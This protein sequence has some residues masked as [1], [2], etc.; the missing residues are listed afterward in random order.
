MPSAVVGTKLSSRSDNRS[1]VSTFYDT[2]WRS[3]L[4]VG[5]VRISVIFYAL[6]FSHCSS[7]LEM[8]IHPFPLR[9]AKKR[10]NDTEVSC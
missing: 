5:R 6:S 3:G 8:A 4:T 10:A 1:A 9:L 7:R 2:K